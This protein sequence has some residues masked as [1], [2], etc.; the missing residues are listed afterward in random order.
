MPHFDYDAAGDGFQLPD[1]VTQGERDDTMFRYLSSLRAKGADEQQLMAEAARANA[2]RF[3]PPLTE[4]ELMGRVRSVMRY[5]QGASEFRTDARDIPT[6]KVKTINRVGE[7]SWLDDLSGLSPLEQ[8]HR[9]IEACFEDEDTVCVVRDF[10]GN[11]KYEYAGVWRGLIHGFEPLSILQ[12]DADEGAWVCIN[13]LYGDGE[14]DREDNRRRG[15][16]RKDADVRVYANALVE[17]DELPMDQQLERILALFHGKESLRAIVDSGNKSYH[18]VIAVNAPDIDHYHALVRYL[19]DTCEANGLPVDRHCGN[20]AR[21]MRL[22]G[23]MRG[24]RM[25]RLV[26]V[27]G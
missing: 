3:D 25:Q 26:Y 12:F 18:A 27:N 1:R 14:T 15:Y 2:E 8:Q 22:P 23:V 5:A 13:P 11:E 20:P 17:C 6:P 16:S 9:F 24:D 10:H 19:Y 7:L 4:Q 21:L